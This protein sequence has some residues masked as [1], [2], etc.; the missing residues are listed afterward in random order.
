M[1]E[2]Y[3]IEKGD[4][5]G[6][7]SIEQLKEL[8]NIETYVWFE[9]MTDWKKIKDVPEL[10]IEFNINTTQEII[11]PEN[12]VSIQDNLPNQEINNNGKKC[13]ENYLAL[14]IISTVLCCWPI[15]IAAIVNAS[16]VNSAFSA[17][18]YI[19]AEDYSEKAKKYSIASIILGFV[20]LIIYYA[21]YFSR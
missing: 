5:K 19:D 4:Q 2:Y 11:T 20:G 7:V 14:A 9:G 1:I 18:K 6:P 3:Y 13:P 16:K 21:L 15:G 12:K 17:G 10:A 8:A